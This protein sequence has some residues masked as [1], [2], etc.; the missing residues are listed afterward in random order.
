MSTSI[1]VVGF[2]ASGKSS[3]VEALRARGVDA[4]SVA[5]EH[6][7]VSDLWNH[8]RPDLVVFLD[9]DLDNVRKRRANPNWPEWIYA[10]QRERLTSARSRADVVVDTSTKTEDQVLAVVV[11]YL[12]LD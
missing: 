9:V 8:G 7:I 2:C 10:L 1:V 3:L 5:Q 12:R 4:R 11:N 6:S